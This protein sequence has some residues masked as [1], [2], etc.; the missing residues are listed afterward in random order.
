[1]EGMNDMSESIFMLYGL[2]RIQL[3]TVG[4]AIS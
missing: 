3:L 4:G 2:R 1:M